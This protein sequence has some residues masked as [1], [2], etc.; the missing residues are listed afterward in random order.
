[1]GVCHGSLPALVADTVHTILLYGTANSLLLSR[2]QVAGQH[3]SRPAAS[4]Q[5]LWHLM[6]RPL[7]APVLLAF[8]HQACSVSCLGFVGCV[9]VTMQCILEAL[10]HC[11]LCAAASPTTCTGHTHTY[12]I[13]HTHTYPTPCP[14]LVFIYVRCTDVLVIIGGHQPPLLQRPVFGWCPCIGCGF[15]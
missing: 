7:V 5:A 8:G 6:S 14:W 4:C 12:T 15:V 1:M 9:L 2:Q 3:K 13:T 11:M 10:M